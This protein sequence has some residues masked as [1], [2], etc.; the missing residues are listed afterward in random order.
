MAGI[1]AATITA[2]AA[3]LN[4]GE[5]VEN[6]DDDPFAYEYEEDETTKEDE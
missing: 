3:K 2:K 6:E 4:N 5:E 1:A